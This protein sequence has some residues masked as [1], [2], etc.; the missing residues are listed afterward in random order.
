[1]AEGKIIMGCVAKILEQIPPPGTGEARRIVVAMSGGVDSS[2]SAALYAA[3]G[4]EVIGVTMQLYDHGEAVGRARSC[5]AGRDIHD[6]RNVAAD[7]GIDH[8]VVDYEHRFRKSVMDEFAG[9]YLAGETPVP[10]IRCN[11]TVKFIDLVNFA[12]DLGASALVTGH[13]VQRKESA[14]GPILCQGAEAGRDQS[15]FMFSIT[16]EQLDFL[17]FPLGGLTKDETRA[18]AAEL[19]L[20]VAAKPDSQDICF[21]PEGDYASVV[22]KLAPDAQKP[23]MILHSDGRELGRHQGIAGFTIGQRR[24]LGVAVGSPLF[25]TSIDAARGLVTVGPREDTMVRQVHLRAINWM[26]S[27]KLQSGDEIE[28]FVK[29]RSTSPPAP[30]RLGFK[31][32]NRAEIFLDKAEYGVSAGQACVFYDSASG[33]AHMLGGG[34]ISGTKK[35]S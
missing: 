31:D 2:V 20:R 24:R 8:Y 19:G 11:E 26:G 28:L 13:Y 3:K 17:R 27:T 30:A 33:G 9:S 25:V 34:W 5:C 6:A 22:R 10:C 18:L 21:V 29:L 1:M 12:R 23:G 35:N 32:K 15:Y 16:P 7:I 14:S 4:Y